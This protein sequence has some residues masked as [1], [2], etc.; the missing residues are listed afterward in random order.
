M[1]MFSQLEWKKSNATT[2][3]EVCNYRLESDLRS[4][5]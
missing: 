3:E 2:Q 4:V 5:N 1:E